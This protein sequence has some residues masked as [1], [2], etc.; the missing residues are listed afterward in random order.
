MSRFPKQKRLNRI[1]QNSKVL[2]LVVQIRLRPCLPV[3]SN[4]R[5]VVASSRAEQLYTRSTLDVQT[6]AAWHCVRNLS[7]I[8]TITAPRMPTLDTVFGQGGVIEGEVLVSDPVFTL[9]MR[10]WVEGN[11]QMLVHGH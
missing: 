4:I 7:R 1:A 2:F 8:L 11:L 9:S 3:A 10:D 6:L 5:M